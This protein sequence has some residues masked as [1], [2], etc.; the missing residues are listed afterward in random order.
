MT[1]TS[2]PMVHV[3]IPSVLRNHVRALKFTMSHEH[4]TTEDNVHK[5]DIS[6]LNASSN[7][8]DDVINAASDVLNIGRK[9]LYLFITDNESLDLLRIL[10]KRSIIN[11]EVTYYDTS[12]CTLKVGTGEQSYAEGKKVSVDTN[13]QLAGWHASVLDVIFELFDHI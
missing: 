2:L 3:G 1:N 13:G 10:H 6:Q 7:R 5:F 12:E 9:P 4:S 11:L 8:I